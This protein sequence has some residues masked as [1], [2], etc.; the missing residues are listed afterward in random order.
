MLCWP[1][2]W[3]AKCHTKTCLD[4]KNNVVGCMT[5]DWRPTSVYCPLDLMF[6]C[7]L[8][9][10]LFLPMCR[11][12]SLVMCYSIASLWSVLG[13]ISPVL[14]QCKLYCEYHLRLIHN[15]C[16]LTNLHYY[17]PV[18]LLPI[19][20][21]FFVFISLSFLVLCCLCLLTNICAYTCN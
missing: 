7:C 1:V 17:K 18:L 9:A 19:A 16:I 8:V 20:F 2:S 6:F 13:C 10:F 15:T 21:I 5:F 14:L 4:F 11:L 12:I 3:P